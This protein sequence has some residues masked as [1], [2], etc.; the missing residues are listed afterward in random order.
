MLQHRT[1]IHFHEDDEEHH[2]QSQQGIEVERDSLN[3][4]TDAVLIF[5]E[6]RHR[7]R[8]RRNGGNDANRCRRRVNQVC[9]LGTAYLVLVGDRAHD[10]THG[11]AVEIV[12]DEYQT[13]QQH[14]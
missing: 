12:I 7:S 14:G 6:S 9:Q 4:D 5:D 2:Q 3:E 8:P 13:A 10:R 1:K 11:Q